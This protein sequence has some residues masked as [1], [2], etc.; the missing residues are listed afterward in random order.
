MGPVLTSARAAGERNVSAFGI[1]RRA[2]K[3]DFGRVFGG[4]ISVIRRRFVPVL[5]LTLAF[6]VVPSAINA[7][8]R[9]SLFGDLTNAQQIANPYWWLVSIAVGLVS[10]IGEAAL[11]HLTV[12]ELAGRPLPAVDS[13]RVGLRVFFPILLISFLTFLGVAVGFA[14]LFVPGVILVLMWIVV[15]PVYVTEQIGIM[16]VFGRSR[17]LTKGNRWRLLGLLILFFIV[18]MVIEWPLRA[19]MGLGIASGQDLGRAMTPALLSTPIYALIV[20]PVTYIGLG[21]LYVELRRCRDGVGPE[22]LAA[23][24]D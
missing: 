3:M 18:V 5:V 9:I 21:S 6:A 17:A 22:G 20:T 15:L 24:F 11:L 12:S 8:L 19:A 13:L 1:E 4:A 7:A 16:G 23:V 10:V 14:L 2:E